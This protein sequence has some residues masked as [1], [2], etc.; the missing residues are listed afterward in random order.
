M[1]KVTLFCLI[2]PIAF[3]LLNI[4]KSIVDNKDN[5]KNKIASI[6][7]N[8]LLLIALFIIKYTFVYL[9]Q[10]SRFLLSYIS[11]NLFYGIITLI[12]VLLINANIN[13]GNGHIQMPIFILCV[14]SLIILLITVIIGYGNTFFN[15]KPT[16]NSIDKTEATYKEAPTFKQG[17]TPVAISPKTI[18][19]RLS[20]VISDVPNS[21]YFKAAGKDD[22]EAQFINGKPSYIIPIEYQGFFQYLQSNRTLPGYFIIDATDE[23]AT[24]KFVKC[25]MKYSNSS[26]F[27]RNAE[28][29]IYRHF[30]TYITSSSNPQLQIGPDNTP[31]WVETLYKPEALSYRPNYKKLKVAVLNAKNGDAKLYSINK[32]PKFISTGITSDVADDMNNVYGK[33]KYG[34]MNKWFGHKG[35]KKPTENGPENGVTTIFNSNGT[36]S[37]FADFTNINNDNNSGVGYSMINARTGKLTY[38]KVDGMMDS[39]GAKNNADEN[40]KA[41]K[42]HASMPIIYNISGRP[43][44][45]MQ[46]LDSTNAIR[47]YYYLDAKNQTIHAN[48]SDVSDALAQFNQAL[49]S[50]NISASNTSGIKEKKVNGIID[51]FAIISS[52]HK[53]MFT[54]QGSSIIYTLNTQDDQNSVLVKPGDQVSFKANIINGK[55][56]GNVNNFKDKQLGNN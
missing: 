31:Y 36:I 32:L 4:I 49:N 45:V 33:D 29:Q 38:Y 22:I 21:Q 55:S 51:R 19:S 44:W 3:I 17:E 2:I 15:V 43:A 48:A 12:L 8:I 9:R 16:Y 39:D 23:S 24:P 54:L 50:S 7:L 25:K 35:M 47:G 10:P 56:Q 40:Y 6:S 28:R 37:Y 1:I 18:E 26:Y 27:G 34:I 46:I 14:S 42:W 30:P 53:V 5:T 41:Q 13:D 52:N 20:K 11:S